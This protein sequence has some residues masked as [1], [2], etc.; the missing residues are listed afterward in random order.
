[1]CIINQYV[2][3]LMHVWRSKCTRLIPSGVDAHTLTQSRNWTWE[4]KSDTI[5]IR[6]KRIRA[7]YIYKNVCSPPVVIKPNS[8]I[9][10][11]AIKIHK[12]YT[13][14]VRQC[15]WKAHFYPAEMGTDP[16]EEKQMISGTKWDVNFGRNWIM[17][18]IVSVFSP[19]N[20]N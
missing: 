2:Y 7:N 16:T 13:S 5:P 9:E 18:E 3:V 20:S 10:I 14:N 1:M 12:I 19:T 11:I 15:F 8:R 4:K 17:V 6:V